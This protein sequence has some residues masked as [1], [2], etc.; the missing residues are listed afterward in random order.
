MSRHLKREPFNFIDLF[1]GLGG[2]HQA[3]VANGGTCV[4]ACDI[5]EQCRKV[6]AENFCPNGEFPVEGDIN[7]SIKNK[8]IPSFQFLCAGFPCQTFSKA[9]NRNGFAVIKR[10]NGEDDERGQ[11]FFR[12]VDILKEHPECN[13]ILLENVRN[14]ADNKE[15][16]AII[17]DELKKLDFIISEDPIIESPHHFGVPQ[18]RERVYILGIRRSHW[19][20][21]H[22]LPYGYITRKDIRLD[23]YLCPCDDN[24]SCISS[25]LDDE[26]R[27][28]Y[29]VPKDINDL[30][31]AW[32][33]FR[34]RANGFSRPFWLPYAG[35]GIRKRELYLADKT[36]SFNDMPAWK[37]LIVMRIRECYERNMEMIDEWVVKHNM[38]ERILIHQKFEWNAGDKY[39]MK[40]CIIQVRQSG[41]RVKRPNYFPSLVAMNNTAIV[42]DQKS[43]HYRYLSPR[44]CA[45]LQ[46]FKEDYKFSE[47]DSV[48]YR[49]L[50]N[51]VNVKILSV[52]AHELIN[53]GK[54]V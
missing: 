4:F 48:S 52:L 50:G 11:L 23:D 6:Y 33:D 28:E 24:A 1:C 35:V 30:L 2:F 12:I 16:W 13:F 19:D 27:P 18:I 26:Y 22:R 49:Q 41:V 21:R 5:D 34:L 14:L 47:I 45:K 3:L 37:K 42:W 20:R 10:A 29:W 17:C 31:L 9:G 32:E 54:K 39:Y 7:I 40:D 51:S 44:E 53:L 15:N 25:I 8:S 43:N 38:L 36:I 46:S